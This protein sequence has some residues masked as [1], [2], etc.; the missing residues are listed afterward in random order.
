MGGSGVEG[1]VQSFSRLA[2]DSPW[3]TWVLSFP[4]SCFTHRPSCFTR[5]PLLLGPKEFGG[6]AA[7]YTAG[8]PSRS[9]LSRALFPLPDARDHVA[10]RVT[11]SPV[12]GAPA[13]SAPS[14]RPP[15]SSVPKSSAAAS[16][17]RPTTAEMSQPKQALT[18]RT[19]VGRSSRP[20]A[21]WAS[22]SCRRGRP[23]EG[24]RCSGDGA[25]PGGA[26]GEA[27]GSDTARSVLS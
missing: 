23:R 12:P 5:F 4:A 13:E 19:D 8:S 27:G 18:R 16:I 17:T 10:P 25:A 1:L 14:P 2:G 22:S 11:R 20:A 9:S 24:S 26:G 6:R 21:G 3:A 15:L 7:S